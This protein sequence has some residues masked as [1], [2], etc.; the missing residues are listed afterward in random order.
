MVISKQKASKKRIMAVFLLFAVIL[1]FFMSRV[2][3]KDAGVK[4]KAVRIGYFHG[5]RTRQFYRAYVNKY[6]EKE[7][8]RIR[9]FTKTLRKQ[10]LLEAPETYEEWRGI[11][12]KDSNYGDI[13]GTE[14]VDAIVRGELDGGTIGE[15]SF[16]L[17]VNRGAPIVAVSNMGHI[18]KG[19]PA[20]AIVLRKEVK[21]KKPEDLKGRTF[22][23]RLSGPLDN[24][25]IRSFI[26]SE[27]LK[28]SDVK[29]ID[30][31]FHDEQQAMLKT[32]KADGGFF[33]LHSTKK[34]IRDEVGY[35]YRKFDWINPEAASGILVF[36]RDFVKNNG[37]AVQRVVNAYA[38]R[39]KYENSLS[40]EEKRNPKDE[41]PEIVD[42]SIE[43]MNL[44]QA[45]YPPK[46]RPDMLNLIQDLMLKY[47]EIKN[48]VDFT[49]QIDFSFVKKAAADK[50]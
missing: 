32:G 28:L 35:I 1:G 2:E 30:E 21:A 13:T 8:I 46:L 50:D 17:A 38:K 36:H 47:G 7:K 26:E 49:P 41:G 23:S 22:I 3:A 11:E 10:G 37:D 48:R 42:D 18:V 31:V 29:F 24:I 33:H 40:P 12:L 27:G 6:F 9:L 45:D 15:A 19:A 5:G 4:L 39:I 25:M 16:L 34:F 43:G 14:I 20:Y 44:P